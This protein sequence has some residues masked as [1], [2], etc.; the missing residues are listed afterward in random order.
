MLR[1]NADWAYGNAQVRLIAFELKV[2]SELVLWS[3][4]AANGVVVKADLPLSRPLP[5]CD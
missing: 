5:T 2:G 1:H 4:V 3:S